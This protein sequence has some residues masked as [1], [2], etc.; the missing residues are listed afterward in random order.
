[1]GPIFGGD[2]NIAVLKMLWGDKYFVLQFTVCESRLKNSSCNI[3]QKCMNLSPT[4]ASTIGFTA[5]PFTL[6]PSPFTDH[7][8]LLFPLH[9]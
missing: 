2:V 5:A 6:Y 8:L 1:M 7:R 3:F 4:F 9:P